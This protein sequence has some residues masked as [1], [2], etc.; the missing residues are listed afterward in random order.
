MF[1]LTL[2]VVSWAAGTKEKKGLSGEPVEEIYQRIRAAGPQYEWEERTLTFQNQG[3]NLVAT[4]VTPKGIRRPPI[5]ITLNGFAEDRFYKEI[6]NTGGEH[7]YP[8]LS[9]ILAEQGIATMRVDYRGSGDSDGDYTMTTFS[10]QV[11]DA[12]AAVQYICTAL[13]RAV[14]W[15][16]LAMLGFSQGGLVTSVAASLDDHIDSI[17]LLSAVASPPITYSSL[18]PLDGI[19]QG[20]ALPDGGTITL[21]IYVGDWYL[22]DIELGKGFFQDM[23][24]VN[25]PAA[26]RAYKGPML[27]VAGIK[28]IIVW[29]QPLA[30]QMFIDYHD[31]IEKLVVLDGDHEFDSDYSFEVFDEA[32]YWAAAWFIKTL[33]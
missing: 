14:D 17:V 18:L 6:P 10:T 2:A 4:L 1:V 30:G 9:R 12:L 28:D 16:S 20:L 5:V 27:Y 8:R 32:V 25:P 22:G 3:M 33:D 21:P 13:R 31:G 11:S 19:K 23:F 24:L 26:V 29:P 15:K 7:F